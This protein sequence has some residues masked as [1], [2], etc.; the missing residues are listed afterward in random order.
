MAPLIPR[1]ES[2]GVGSKPLAYLIQP[3]S[4]FGGIG[5]AV[6][7]AAELVITRVGYLGARLPCYRC[8]ISYLIG[9]CVIIIHTV[10][11]VQDSFI[12]RVKLTTKHGIS[13][14]LISMH[15]QFEKS[16]NEQQQVGFG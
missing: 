12:I 10:V 2:A 1:I 8:Y 9:S 4:D 16:K 14:Q 15:S 5:S 7:P 11:H 6:T 13:P 3:G